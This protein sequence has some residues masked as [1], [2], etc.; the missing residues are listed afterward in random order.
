MTPAEGGAAPAPEVERAVLAAVLVD[1]LQLDSVLQ[2]VAESGVDFLDERHKRVFQAICGLDRDGEG[3]S[4]DLVTVADR[5]QQTGNLEAIGGSQFLLDLTAGVSVSTNAEGYARAVRQ[6]SQRRK[7]AGFAAKVSEAAKK[8]PPAETLE[9]AEKELFS[10]AEGAHDAPPVLIE[11]EVARLSDEADRERKA[12]GVSTGF[13]ELD[14]LTVRL[15]K[16]DLIL[17]GG[18]PG[19]GKTSLGLNIA[20]NAALD[21]HTVLIFSLE[22]PLRQIVVRLLFSE[23]EVDTKHLQKSG[24]L[25]GEQIRKVRA[26]AKRIRKAPVFVDDSN[27]TP[28]ELRSKARQLS[29]ERNGLDLIVVDYLQ[30]M[31]GA[32]PGRG[33]FESRT[34][35]IAAISRGLKLLARELDCPI[36][37]LSQLNRAKEQGSEFAPPRLS[38]L[39]ESGALEQDADIVLLLHRPRQKKAASDE[40]EDEDRRDARQIR[41]VIVAKNRN[42]RTGTAELAWMAEYT[43]FASRDPSVED[44]PFADYEE[45]TAP[46]DATDF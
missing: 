40:A 6:H 21:G 37:A 42:G 26:A 28:V 32:E 7:L 2:H 11:S 18:R 41:Q 44:R 30:L 10:I 45:F 24:R 43:R 36:L 46:D 29:R 4:I 20:L 16:S 1:P 12:A 9:M 38:H 15:K 33:R 8:A 19:E 31:S 22:M 23:A 5:L 39:R 13:R 25:G 35:E 14:D 17:V 34:L 3:K 27:V